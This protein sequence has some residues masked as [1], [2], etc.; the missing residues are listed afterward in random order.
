[1]LFMIGEVCATLGAAS[2]L[3]LLLICSGAFF[4]TKLRFPGFAAAP[5]AEW[6][7][8]SLICGLACLPVLLDLGG[9]LGVRA[10]VAVALA[11][12]A[13]GVPA[14]IAKGRELETIRIGPLLGLAAWA[15]GVV[16]I[17]VDM[18]VADGLAHSLLVVD[19]VKHAST[20]WAIAASAT[21]PYNPTF[22]EP[23]GHASYY[24]FFYTL[25]A[26]V[27]LIL[28]PLGIAA[29]H[30]AYAG[31]IVI[32]PALL[33]LAYATWKRSG[34]DEAVGAKGRATVTLLAALLFATGLD[35][36]PTAL[37]V[38]LRGDWALSPEEWNDQV[39]SWLLSVLWAPH[40]VAAL[41]AAMVGFMAL[42]G[43]P[44]DGRASVGS[45]RILLAGLSF[46]SLA[47][48]SVY[49][50]MGGALTAAIWTVFLAARRRIGE[51]RRN[52]AAGLLALALA[53]PWAATVLQRAA[54]GEPRPIALA[55]RAFP[56]T[57]VL[58][59]DEPLRSIV[60]LV[61]MPIGYAVEFGV[62]GLGAV[63][64]WRMAG[65][66]GMARDLGLILVIAA[67]VS[68]LIGSFVRSTIL[69]NDLGWRI[70]LFAQLATLVWTAAAVRAGAFSRG[71]PRRAAIV[72]LT[73]AYAVDVYALMQLRL[74]PVMAP[75]SAS[76]PDE[77]AAWRWLDST[78]PRI[79]VVQEDP[80][81]TR[82]YDYG[83]Y[84][85]FPE[86]V[87]DRHNGYLFGAPHAA[88]ERRLADIGPIFV[89]RSLG[90]DA[91]RAIAVRY[92]ISAIVT[93]S[94][95]P[96]FDDPSAWPARTKPDF[97]NAHVRI[98]LL[99]YGAARR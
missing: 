38:W 24:Y 99:S 53:A 74:N 5:P 82:A 29:R 59:Q 92:G 66:R 4:A 52:A 31:P 44:A 46:A 2:C 83:L 17:I 67:C 43:D 49:V 36:I 60:R 16:A 87:S 48:L 23:G 3:A 69:L 28:E 62:F 55:I 20:T 30:V 54:T 93:A 86:A 11:V 6:L 57:D 80:I 95:D 89:D 8:L 98:F 7:G 32:G 37:L 34:A 91:V 27:A 97:A 1:M 10:M 84:G 64:F 19:Y 21:P 56:I 76:L 15:L 71:A 90:V 94:G 39:T 73:L 50:A 41:C 63:L 68:F 81:K 14:V 70:M 22:Y 61:M 47:G 33:A 42:A 65:R 72:C 26:V 77:I 88:V 12:A 79:A 25:T 13:A 9:R 45:R 18:P 58:I 75:H 40:H 85:R 35:L 51:A 78:L 96:V